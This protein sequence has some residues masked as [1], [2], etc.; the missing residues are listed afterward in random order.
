MKSYNNVRI[1]LVD[2]HAIVRWGI[3]ALIERNSEY[4]VV[5]EA[6]TLADAYDLVED[7]KPDLVLLDVKL[8][9]GDGVTGLKRIKMKYPDVKVLML[10][11]YAEKDIIQETMD[12]GASGYL[13]KNIDTKN[14]LG[15][16]KGVLDG[17][18]VIDKTL[19]RAMLSDEDI[20]SN[21]E[22]LTKQEIQILDLVATGKSNKEIGEELFL[23]EKTVRN[24]VS[25]IMGKVNVSNRTEAALYWKRKK[26]LE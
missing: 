10:S 9:D 4:L 16:I 17:K 20:I 26:S 11:A 8:P 25:R 3:K 2:D 14:I 22:V 6:E 19:E 23:A 5:G 15:S 24:Y 18:Y 13:L 1:I 7:L 12:G 21:D